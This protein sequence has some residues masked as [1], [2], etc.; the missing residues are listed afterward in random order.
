VTPPAPDHSICCPGVGA[1][2]FV[3]APASSDDPN[4]DGAVARARH[5]RLTR[6]FGS[7]RRDR[8][9]DVDSVIASD[10]ERLASRKSVA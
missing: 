7:G 9:V 2:A 6:L 10:P 4:G 5:D 3:L 1:T 8:A